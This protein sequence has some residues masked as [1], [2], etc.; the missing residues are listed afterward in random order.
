MHVLK[1]YFNVIHRA[2]K[3]FDWS[4]E[5]SWLH[6]MRLLLVRVCVGIPKI[7]ILPVFVQ[8]VGF[9]ADF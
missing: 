7:G 4:C 5:S 6:F 3:P 1:L 9:E 8:Q 2:N